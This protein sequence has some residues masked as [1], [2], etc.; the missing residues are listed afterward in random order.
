LG[1]P[2]VIF[3]AE[4]K[5]LKPEECTTVA[6]HVENVREVYYE[7]LGVDGQGQKEECVHGD[8]GDY[9]LRV[10]LDNGVSQWYTVT[11]G[12]TPATSTPAPT[13][14][15]TEEPM[16]TET[17]TPEAPTETPTPSVVYGAR[18]EAGDDTS[19][20]CAR[21]STCEFDLYVA[22]TGSAIDSITLRFVEASSWPRQICRLDGVCSESQLT[23]V[24]MGPSNTGVIRLRITVP[25]DAGTDTMTY[26]LEAVSDGSGGASRS[27][28][29]AVSLTATDE[30]TSQAG[31]EGTEPDE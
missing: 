25:A 26:K 27:S 2:I 19:I 17:W 4:D 9:N 30:A 6:W 7:N 24:E 16:P 21:N 31:K 1:T 10:V 28:V 22:N 8:A 3:Y 20:T 18:L 23:F 29:V 13:P 12:M 11:V 15:R 14:T 5:E